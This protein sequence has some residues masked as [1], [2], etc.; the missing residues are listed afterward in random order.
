MVFLGF[1]IVSVNS[2]SVVRSPSSI[3]ASVVQPF[4]EDSP[5]YAELI[6]SKET[7]CRLVLLSLKLSSFIFP[8]VKKK[9]IIAFLLE[10]V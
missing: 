2:S 5:R 3:L 7:S 4:L 8:K 6:D 9:T 10:S 1:S